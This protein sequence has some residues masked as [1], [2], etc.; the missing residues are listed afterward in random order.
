VKKKTGL[1]DERFLSTRINNNKIHHINIVKHKRKFSRISCIAD[2]RIDRVN[3]DKIDHYR[4]NKDLY[5][6]F[7]LSAP[8]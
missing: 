6:D 4:Y 2:N 5:I 1:G 3:L 7:S 8:L